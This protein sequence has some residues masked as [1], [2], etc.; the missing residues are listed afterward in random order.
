MAEKDPA[1]Q[2]AEYTP[3]E[4]SLASGR[5]PTVIVDDVHIIYR[6]HGAAS[7]NS[8]PLN[9]FKRMLTRSSQ[10]LQSVI[11]WSANASG[12]ASLC[13]ATAARNASGNVAIT[14]MRA[15]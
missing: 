12:A 4:V 8:S 14:A 7:A 5:V 15:G 6:I 11:C 3:P 10:R 2:L 1:I 13:T 9:T